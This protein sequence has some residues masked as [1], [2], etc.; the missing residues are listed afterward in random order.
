MNMN[1]RDNWLCDSDG[2]QLNPELPSE[3]ENSVDVK[4][5][6][7]AHMRVTSR[8]SRTAISPEPSID[9]GEDDPTPMAGVDGSPE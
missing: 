6:T 9:E 3:S 4:S 2:E 7:M 5:D 1:S 8:L